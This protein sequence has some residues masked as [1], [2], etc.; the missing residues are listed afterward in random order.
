[1]SKQKLTKN[2]HHLFYNPLQY[3]ARGRGVG[4][5]SPVLPPSGCPEIETIFPEDPKGENDPPLKDT[6]MKPMKKVKSKL[7]KKEKLLQPNGGAMSNKKSNANLYGSDD[8]LSFVE[9]EKPSTRPSEAPLD[10]LEEPLTRPSKAPAI[11]VESNPDRSFGL[12][13]SSNAPTT[14]FE[15][16]ET[17]FKMRHEGWDSDSGVTST[18]QSPNMMEKNKK[19]KRLRR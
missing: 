17:Q 8:D 12:V 11:L 15:R 13:S 4:T 9:L 10:E 16:L 1:M 2:Q 19:G 14:T 18:K 7:D 6:N 3:D 5:N